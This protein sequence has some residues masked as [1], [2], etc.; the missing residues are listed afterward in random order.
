MIG[1]CNG[2][3]K[4]LQLKKT[5]PDFILNTLCKTENINLSAATV[6][7]GSL[8]SPQSPTVRDNV[9]QCPLMSSHSTI[10]CHQMSPTN[11]SVTTIFPLVTVWVS[12][13]N[14]II[15]IYTNVFIRFLLVEKLHRNCSFKSINYL[16]QT[17]SCIKMLISVSFNN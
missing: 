11:E 14:F 15:C 8:S 13:N 10:Y 3:L 4:F 12:L 6:E 7:T 17:V 16:W 5:K 9:T 2:T 1:I